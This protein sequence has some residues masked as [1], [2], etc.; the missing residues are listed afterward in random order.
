MY[1]YLHLYFINQ[2]STCTRDSK[3]VHKKVLLRLYAY[4]ISF[5]FYSIH[6]YVR[7]ILILYIRMYV[8]MCLYLQRI[9]IHVH[10]RLYF[11]LWSPIFTINNYCNIWNLIHTFILIKSLQFFI[12]EVYNIVNIYNKYLLQH[13]ESNS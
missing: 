8:S 2:T 5:H 12:L 9:H 1:F 10:S 3:V 7:Y 4:L 6:I 13:L 11:K